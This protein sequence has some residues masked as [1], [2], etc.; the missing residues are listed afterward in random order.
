MGFK[1]H[2]PKIWRIKYAIKAEGI[3]KT[4]EI[5]NSFWNPFQPSLLFSATSNKRYLPCTMR[6][7]VSPETELGA[8]KSVQTFVTLTLYSSYCLP[9]YYF[10]HNPL[11]LSVL[12]K[13]IVSLSKGKTSYYV[14]SG[15]HSLVK[16]PHCCSIVQSCSTLLRPHGRQ[17][18]GLPCPSPSADGELAQSYVHWFG[19]AIPPSH[20]LS[21]SFPAFNLSQHQGVFQGVRWPKY[22]SFGFSISPSKE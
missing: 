11:V 22:W 8:K 21:S 7:D 5:R 13:I 12:H 1:E 20:H 10:W 19:D 17:H 3:L 14:T 18:T 6:Q 2:S 16:I 4:E 9:I 15:L